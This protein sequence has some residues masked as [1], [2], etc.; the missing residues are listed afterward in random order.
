MAKKL[1]ISAYKYILHY[2]LKM[3]Y[4]TFDKQKL[5]M[6][7]NC[8]AAFIFIL[9]VSCSQKSPYPGYTYDRAGFHFQLLTLGESDKKAAFGDYISANIKY[10]TLND[11]LFFSGKRKIKLEETTVKNGIEACFLKL[12]EQESANFII[13]ANDFYGRTLESS[14]PSFLEED[15]FLKVYIEILEIQKP[16]D[17]DIEK[18][19]FLNWIEDFGDYEKVILQ[20]YLVDQKLPVEADKNGFYLLKTTEGNGKCIEEGDTITINYEGRFLNGKF[21]DST[22]RRNQPFQFVYGTEWQVIDGLEKALAYMCNGDK[23]LV[24]LPSEMAF[25]SR[26]SSTGIIP[27]Y[28]SLIFEVEILNVNNNERLN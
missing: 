4:F 19:A 17:F 15:G 5:Y 6:F 22:K 8:I 3:S 21:F 9:L 2:A 1:L 23:A 27:P 20:K 13:S 11:S 12:R 10:Y 26:G 18:L 25:G 24:I 14:L 16:E 7:R 28:T